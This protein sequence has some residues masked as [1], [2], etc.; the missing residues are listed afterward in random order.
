MNKLLLF[1]LILFSHQVLAQKLTKTE[2]K[3]L[4]V[5]DKNYAESLALLQETVD[6]NSGTLNMEGVR[7][8]G[9]V[10]EREFAKIGFQ[11]EWITLPDSLKRA[12]HFVATKKGNKGKKL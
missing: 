12:G 11:T 2:S 7:E 9:R 5:I 8:V 3:L 10:F 6:I 1:A 4:S